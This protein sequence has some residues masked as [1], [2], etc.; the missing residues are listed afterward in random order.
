MMTIKFPAVSNMGVAYFGF[1]KVFQEFMSNVNE[2]SIKSILDYGCGQGKARF[3]FGD[4]VDYHGVDIIDIEDAKF[5]Y[6]KLCSAKLPYDDNSFD[7]VFSNFVIEYIPDKEMFVSEIYR[8]LKPGGKFYIGSCGM[9]AY[10]SY[11]IFNLIPNKSYAFVAKG[12]GIKEDDL[13]GY[14]QKHK[15]K[16]IE[17]RVTSG[18]MSSGFKS[19]HIIIRAIEKALRLV[20]N[21]IGFT[22]LKPTSLLPLPIPNS[23]SNQEEYNFYVESKSGNSFLRE[24]FYG[25]L[26]NLGVNE[27]KVLEY[28]VFGEKE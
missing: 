26:F 10:L 7:M 20:L 21:R 8:V 2:K 12:Q 11:S 13:L 1:T 3:L 23:V 5:N 14:L 17:S 19:I 15:F 4:E 27:K 16:N 28:A 9:K 22:S 18:V 25:Y 24:R 6:R